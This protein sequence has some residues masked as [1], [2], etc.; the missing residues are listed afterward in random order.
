MFDKK[1]T[2]KYN[3]EKREDMNM[4]YLGGKIATDT[5]L[6]SVVRLNSLIEKNPEIL[7]GLKE[8]KYTAKDTDKTFRVINFWESVG[9]LD[10]SR[11]DSSA[12]WRKFSPIDVVYMHILS[13]LREFGLSIQQLKTV[14]TDL[15]K[16]LDIKG[17]ALHFSV[18][19][20][21]YMRT[22]SL[23]NQG[24]TY[25]VVD[26]DGHTYCTSVKDMLLADDIDGVPEGC[27]IINLNK[28][29]SEKV[30]FKNGATVP[31]HSERAY[32]LDGKGEEELLELL[33]TSEYNSINITPKEDGSLL[34]ERVFTSDGNDDFPEYGDIITKVQ[35]GR[36]V[37]RKVKQKTKIK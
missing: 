34:I 29:L 36:I 28:M 20:Y 31:I 15:T 5:T 6:H 26:P 37:S 12:K 11:E 3:K 2:Y 18:L 25:L 14:K 4:D 16:I 35:D 1:Y 19:E 24:N 13:K 30:N 27:I 8:K 23:K 22:I 7:K 9:L 21:A 33:R 32:V 17:V 10:N